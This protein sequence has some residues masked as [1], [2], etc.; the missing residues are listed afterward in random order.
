MARDRSSA[1]ANAVSDV[2]PESIQ[3]ADRFHLLDNLTTQ[4]KEL[5]KLELPNHFFIKNTKLVD[6]LTV[7]PSQKKNKK[8]IV[9]TS[10]SQFDKISYD[11]SPPLDANGMEILFNS[12]NHN[13]KNGQIYII[14]KEN[15]H[16]KRKN[17]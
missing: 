12:R 8:L 7:I 5:S 16:K 15:W 9:K 4:F 10:L 13:V 14:Q 3:V 6:Q 2:L 17:Y 11:N 1:F